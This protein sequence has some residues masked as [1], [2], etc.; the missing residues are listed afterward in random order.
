M[1]AL[2]VHAHPEPRSFVA[3]MRDAAAEQLSAMGYEPV[4]SDLYAQGFDPVVK[5]AD[6][7]QRSDPAYLN[8]ALEQRHGHKAG[9]LPADIARELDRVLH[10]DL[11][12]LT[13]PLFW[14]SVP[15]ILKGWFDRVL[16]SGPIYG[17]RRFYARGGLAGKRG[18]V[19]MSLG[20]RQP[21]FEG[22]DAIHGDLTGILK[23]VLQGTLGYSGMTVMPPFYA[24]HVP[25]VDDA[26]R[27]QM[28]L[29]WQEHLAHLDELEPLM[30]PDL[31]A[32]DPQMNPLRRAAE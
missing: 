20:G 27:R 26:A 28:L 13:F 3:A 14:F 1:R 7:P 12:V 19:G 23:P 31:S 29:Q 30:M 4:I 8:I 17:G 2:I 11:I 25:Y 32:Y 9:S 21:M 10:A 22:P 6:F 16:L 24:Y 18:V 15:A 5:A